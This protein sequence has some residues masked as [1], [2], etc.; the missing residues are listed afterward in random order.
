MTSRRDFLKY[1]GAV[2][3]AATQPQL[4]W[5]QQTL[6]ARPIPGTDEQLAVIGLGNSQAFRSGDRDS[7][8]QLLEIFLS[9]GGNY[10]DVGGSSALVVGELGH[11]MGKTDQLFL[12][13]YLDPRDDMQDVARS[14]A[15]AQH[16]SALD[17]V[18]TRSLE[19][20]RSSHDSYRALKEEGLVRYIGVARTG[21]SG[22][23]AMA[24]LVDD[25]LVDFIQVNYSMMEPQAGE[26]LLPLAMDRGVGVAISRPFINGDYFS[27][28]RGHALP[29]W[30]AEFDCAT[31]AQF[32]LK[33][34]LSHPAVTCVLTETANPEHA[35]DNIGAGFGRL[36]DDATRQRMLAHM[37]GLA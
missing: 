7:A 33:F 30:A 12:G 2:T 4:S 9:R 26:R 22:F 37:R 27:I 21:A 6:P 13:N 17:L 16:K 25:G 29:E 34:I 8:G 15:G 23:E 1:T 31:W 36:P 28:I 5:A 19:G 10:V 3:L 11:S 14:L 18:H 24:G 20:F 32:S 35:V